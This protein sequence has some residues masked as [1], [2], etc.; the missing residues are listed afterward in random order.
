M[1]YGFELP[2]KIRK[3]VEAAVITHLGNRHLLTGKQLTTMTDP[4]LG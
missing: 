2:V 4:D 3:G 1:R